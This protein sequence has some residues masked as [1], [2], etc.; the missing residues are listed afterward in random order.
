MGSK[1]QW[2][3]CGKA[4]LPNG[5]RRETEVPCLDI[6]PDSYGISQDPPNV[7]L[8]TKLQFLMECCDILNSLQIHREITRLKGMATVKSF[9]SCTGKPSTYHVICVLIAFLSDSMLDWKIPQ[10]KYTASFTFASPGADSRHRPGIYTSLFHKYV[11]SSL[12]LDYT[13]SCSF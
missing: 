3:H 1:L 7:P 5:R 8:W 6:L 12:S 10:S 9:W 4:L 11:F 2:K 13:P